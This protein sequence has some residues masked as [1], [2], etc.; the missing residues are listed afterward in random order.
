MTTPLI[1]I[2]ASGLARE[3]LACLEGQ[4]YYEVVGILDD[5]PALQGTSVGGV[6]VLGPIS[7]VAGQPDAHLLICAGRGAVRSA[8]LDRLTALGVTEDRFARVVDPSVRIRSSCSVGAGSILLA[9][10]VLTADVTVGRHVVIMPNVT[11]THDDRVDDF[12]TLCAG[13]TLGGTVHVERGAYVG[14]NATVRENLTIG[15]DSTLGMGAALT[16]DLPAGETWIGTPARRLQ[17]V[18]APTARPPHNF[19]SEGLPA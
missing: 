15:A 13:V 10:S 9:G 19:E 6:P 7:A 8:I 17:R 16:R 2:A 14:M 4:Y 3:V 18:T 1:L 5:S 11:L 12:A